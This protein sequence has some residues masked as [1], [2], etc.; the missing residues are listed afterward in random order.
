M[1]HHQTVAVFGAYGHTALFVLGELRRRGL[2]PVLVGR[3]RDRLHA[4]GRAYPDSPV[5][6]A[7]VDDPASL[8]RALLGADAVVNCA[9]P[10]AD[11]APALIDAALRARIPYLDVGAE[12]AVA[13]ETFHNRQEQARA[14][15]VVVVPA[16]AFY[17]GL[18]DLLATTAMGDWPEAEAIDIAFGLDSWEPTQGTRK[19]GRRN[20]GRHVV[21]TGGRFVPPTENPDPTLWEFPEP[22]GVQEVTEFST[23]DQVTASR[24]LRT[25]DIRAHMNLAPL[26]DVRDPATP[27]PSA[28]DGSGRSSQTFLVDAVVHRGGQRRRA[29]ASG[30]DIYAVTAPLVAEATAR[31][32]DGRIREGGAGGVYAAGELFDAEDFLRALAPEHL[33]LDLPARAEN[34]A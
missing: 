15:G 19:T 3:D 29:S 8:D 20:A 10:F 2:T 23:A 9:G 28:A 31:V 33:S 14:A 24:H 25:P 26:R 30:R 5:R 13:L 34:S 18:G 21:Y 27:A 16:L 11:T 4:L 6:V 17:G 1:S 22:L 12:Q 7:S 32:L